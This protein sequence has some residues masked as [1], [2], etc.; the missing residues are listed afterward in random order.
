[1]NTK[2]FHAYII[3]QY[4]LEDV[5]RKLVFNILNYVESQGFVDIEDN[6]SHLYALLGD[7]FGLTQAEIEK[8]IRPFEV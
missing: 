7:V 5:S 6:I 2:E 8:N 4:Q 3:S 1:M